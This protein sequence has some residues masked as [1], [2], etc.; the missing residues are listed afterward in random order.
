M[1]P[2][3]VEINRLLMNFFSCETGKFFKGDERLNSTVA[4]PSSQPGLA[5]PSLRLATTFQIWYLLSICK[6]DNLKSEKIPTL[7]YP[8]CTF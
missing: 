6:K 3:D 1:V 5:F 2:A 4:G 7:C 8:L